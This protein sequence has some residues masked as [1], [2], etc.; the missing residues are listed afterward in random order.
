MQDLINPD[1]LSLLKFPTTNNNKALFQPPHV[2]VGDRILFNH[3]T[4]YYSVLQVGMDVVISLPEVC[5]VLLGTPE[6]SLD[7]FFRSRRK[8]IQTQ[9]SQEAI[10]PQQ[11]FMSPGST[12]KRRISPGY[13][14]VSCAVQVFLVL[15]SWK[16]KR[17]R[18]GYLHSQR[19]S[20]WRGYWDTFGYLSRPWSPCEHTICAT[21]PSERQRPFRAGAYLETITWQVTSH[22]PALAFVSQRCGLYFLVIST[23]VSQKKEGSMCG[24]KPSP[25][26][27]RRR[28]PCCTLFSTRPWDCSTWL[29]EEGLHS[30]GDH[31]HSVKDWSYLCQS[32]YGWGARFSLPL[33]CLRKPGK[34]Y[35]SEWSRNSTS[36]HSKANNS[37]TP[38]QTHSELDVQTSHFLLPFATASR[39]PPFFSW[40]VWCARRIQSS[41]SKG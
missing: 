41:S 37:G 1:L 12:W 38:E 20:T 4:K 33:A 6:V 3:H 18:I 9:I 17:R 8:G 7:L 36:C 30:P 14:G 19:S 5:G 10:C 25:T 27:T 32:T 22:Q 40:P 31:T 15:F 16:R 26:V 11:F 39:W 28:L 21:K 35:H 34:S 24:T 2:P 13:P 23:S 29:H